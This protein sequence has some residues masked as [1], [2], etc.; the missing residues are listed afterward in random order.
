MIVGRMCRFSVTIAM[1]VM[2][3]LM[4][5]LAASAQDQKPEGKIAFIQ[6]GDIWAW[7]E[8]GTSKVIED[9]NAQDPTWSP[10]G[11]QILYARNGGSFTNLLIADA[12]SGRI[13]RITDN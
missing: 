2:V 8:D 7:S 5:V 13:T 6:D 9:G 12:D 1:T 10:D 4:P 3:V 11:R